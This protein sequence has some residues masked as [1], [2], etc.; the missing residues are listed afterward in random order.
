MSWCLLAATLSMFNT[1]WGSHQNH[2]ISVWLRE[3]YQDYSGSCP[4]LPAWW[5]GQP[6]HDNMMAMSG[7][8]KA[9]DSRLP[10]S[11]GPK[12][13]RHSAKVLIAVVVPNCQIAMLLNSLGGKL[14]IFSY[15]LCICIVCISYVSI[16]CNNIHI[17]NISYIYIYYI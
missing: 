3:E 2:Q 13:L 8:V 10:R 14:I 11:P 1:T 15:N 16:T 9:K 6:Q 7:H 5:W 12:S 4:A 17:Y